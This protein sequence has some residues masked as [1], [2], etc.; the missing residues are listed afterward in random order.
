MP[1]ETPNVP[2]T[3]TTALYQQRRSLLLARDSGGTI[4]LLVINDDLGRV[5]YFRRLSAIRLPD[6]AAL[7]QRS[8][9]L[10]QRDL[11]IFPPGA[12]PC[13]RRQIPSPP[14]TRSG[15]SST[16]RNCVPRSGRNRSRSWPRDTCVPPST[17]RTPHA[18]AWPAACRRLRGRGSTSPRLSLR[19]GP[20]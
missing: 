6:P 15:A 14:G 5:F 3:N 11:R 17:A 4:T 1:P 20:R 19:G 2:S 8:A 10:L 9:H 12:D 16:P 18:T 13:V 7:V